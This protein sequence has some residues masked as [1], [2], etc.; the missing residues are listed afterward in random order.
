[1][2]V[3]LQSDTYSIDPA[4]FEPLEV[5]NDAESSVYYEIPDGD[6]LS[7][8]ISNLST[9]TAIFTAVESNISLTL[10]HNQGS[11]ESKT[12]F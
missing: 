5:F 12:R 1:M 6:D 3:F 8:Q 10:P 4:I 2:P 7:D 9:P 11:E